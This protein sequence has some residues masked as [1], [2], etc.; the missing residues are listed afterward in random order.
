MSTKNGKTLIKISKGEALIYDDLGIE[1]GDYIFNLKQDKCE[2]VFS[3]KVAKSMKDEDILKTAKPGQYLTAS[4][5]D[6]EP[7]HKMNTIFA[8]IKGF[9]EYVTLNVKNNFSVYKMPKFK[10]VVPKDGFELSKAEPAKE[11][12]VAETAENIEKPADTPAE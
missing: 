8:K 9:E 3:R 10:I 11:E 12:P 2:V 7:Q 4:C 6:E 5:Y 1:D